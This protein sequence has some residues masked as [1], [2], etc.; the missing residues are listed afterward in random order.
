MTR[1]AQRAW[2]LK[3]MATVPAHHAT[4]L[5]TVMVVCAVL[6]AQLGRPSIMC[7]SGDPNDAKYK[8]LLEMGF[9]PVKTRAALTETSG[10]EDA[11]ISK[12]LREA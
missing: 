7:H 9:D 10:D 12:L 11:A 2:W 4:L 1:S 5:C 3:T 8:R 6:N